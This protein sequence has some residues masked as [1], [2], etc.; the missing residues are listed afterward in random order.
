MITEADTCRKYVLPK[1]TSAWWDNEPHFFTEQKPFTDGRILAGTAEV[2]RKAQKR[3]DYLLRYTRD[4]M[5]A[6]VE[7]KATCKTP[8]H[9]IL[10]FG[11]LIGTER[12]LN[13]FPSPDQFRE[14]LRGN[15]R[16]M[17]EIEE[18]MRN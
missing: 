11:Y 16:V 14:R 5:I 12:E 2:R 17:P 8:G 13:A 9:G 7:A 15:Q 6:V 1:F 3:A 4:F 18:S 10:E